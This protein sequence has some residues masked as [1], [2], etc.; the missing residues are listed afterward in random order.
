M[1]IPE[2]FKL[3]CDFKIGRITFRKGVALETVREAAERWWAAAASAHPINRH[4]TEQQRT[5][6]VSAWVQDRV[7]TI[8]D[9]ALGGNKPD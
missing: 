6:G 8:A 1:K 7:G 3:P 4:L 5:D 9:R 2:E